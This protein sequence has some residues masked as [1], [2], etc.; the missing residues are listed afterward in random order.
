MRLLSLTGLLLYSCLSSSLY[1]ASSQWLAQLEAPFQQWQVLIKTNPNLLLEQLHSMPAEHKNTALQQAQYHLL[2]SHASGALV[3]PEQSIQEAQAGLSLVT[4]DEQPWLYHQ[5]QLSQA[6]ALD[7]DGAPASGLD[8]VTQALQWAERHDDANLLVAALMT[9]GTL[10]NSLT[11]YLGAMADLQ[12]AYN[13][14]PQQSDDIARA[15]IA[16]AL[17]LVY[18]YRGEDNLSLPYFQEAVDYYRQQPASVSLSIY[19]YGLGR[20]NKNQ[21]NTDTG[22]AQLQESAKI[23]EQL[24]DHQGVAYALKE[25]AGM[26]LQAQRY[27][28]A[29]RQA[30]EAIQLFRQADNNYM[31]LDTAR[32]L[33][34]IYLAQQQTERAQTWLQQALQALDPVSMPIQRVE[35]AIQQAKVLAAQGH[36]QSA[37]DLLLQSTDEKQAIQ[38]RQSSEQLH[39]LR[40][41]YEL[42][43]QA[44]QN[45]ILN[46]QNQLQQ[47]Q[48]QSQQR[49]NQLL[50]LL[51][52][53]ATLICTL[54]LFLFYRQHSHKRALQQLA[55]T[56]SLT[57]LLNRRKT[58]ALLQLQADL[59]KRHGFDFCVALVDLDHFKKIN[60]SLGHQGGDVVLKHFADLCQ[61]TLRHTDI[62]GRIGGEEFL[63]ALPHT[64]IDDAAVL[65]EKLRKR[66]EDITKMMAL[67][68]L[69]VSISIGLVNNTPPRTAIELLA[70]ADKI[71]YS[72]KDAG[73]NRVVVD[74]PAVA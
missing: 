25:I 30:L 20:A 31:L 44:H 67:T 27:T 11:D 63:I 39:Q 45:Q 32:L 6:L 2:M 24:N 55:D 65:M 72:A 37:F 60:D 48:L 16:G 56:D 57:G 21:G 66:A 15:D 34:S 50:I 47:T 73:R 49:K 51:F 19:L 3:L 42:D 36:Y 26:D 70:Q 33:S 62:V 17:A 61:K 74:I 22:R 68:D 41:R 28:E 35:L 53:C 40:S 9:R 46:A 7:L 1:A 54:L 12:R 10:L 38:N 5:L 43:A 52:I 64:S 29:E 14:A 8:A 59:A 18:E 69:Q 23:S 4:L 58:L 71:L 13:L